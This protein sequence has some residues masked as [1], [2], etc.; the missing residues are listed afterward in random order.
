[1]KSKIEDRRWKM[2]WAR[3]LKAAATVVVAAAALYHQAQGQIVYPNGGGGGGGGGVVVSSNF[4]SGVVY[5]NTSNNPFHVSVTASLV[6]GGTSAQR[7]ELDLDVST[8]GGAFTPIA[9]GSMYFNGA[10]GYVVSN[11][12]PVGAVVSNG[13]AYC[14]TNDSAGSGLVT[15]TIFPG[16]GTISQVGSTVTTT[17]VVTNATT[18]GTANQVNSPDFPNSTP[19]LFQSGSNLVI[20]DVYFTNSYATNMLGTNTLSPS[21]TSYVFTLQ[22]AESSTSTLDVYTNVGTSPSQFI[23]FNGISGHWYIATNTVNTNQGT[24]GSAFVA[25]SGTAIATPVAPNWTNYA[26]TKITGVNPTGDYYTNWIYQLGGVVN[27]NANTNQVAI[28]NSTGI[29]LADGSLFTAASGLEILNG[30]GLYMSG[31]GGVVQSAPAYFSLLG[32]TP[33][34]GQN[35]PSYSGMMTIAQDTTYGLALWPVGNAYALTIFNA[36]TNADRPNGD[37]AFSVNQNQSVNGL[38]LVMINSFDTN[39]DAGINETE[40]DGPQL[41]IGDAQKVSDGVYTTTN[42]WGIRSWRSTFAIGP[43]NNLN[44]TNINPYLS[45]NFASGA[46][47][48][49]GSNLTNAPGAAAGGGSYMGTNAPTMN[50]MTNTGTA[51]FLGTV[52]TGGN[53]ITGNASGETNFT[54]LA[55][56]NNAVAFFLTA[57]GSTNYASGNGGILSCIGTTNTEQVMVTN[58]TQ[59]TFNMFGGGYTTAL[60]LATNYGNGWLPV[61]QGDLIALT[62]LVG[63]GT[64][65]EVKEC[66]FIGNQ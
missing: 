43:V 2:A 31:P 12:V 34:P 28:A 25:E 23:L 52:T 50:N 32:N 18:A 15:A 10:T 57:V 30:H 6:I 5:T 17:I 36:Y 63:S 1:M 33:T 3:S 41:I 26:G 8:N 59:H 21:T 45:I 24:V 49:L 27:A 54:Q 40:F 35:I 9:S 53:V 66:T 13:W 62:N 22:G 65:I 47:T 11:N 55:W 37:M 39:A 4:Q 64:V 19:V 16:S 60:N 46:I 29:S 20:A 14:F 7:A 58:L 38:Q 51:T 48:G 42:L 61:K 44:L 56:T